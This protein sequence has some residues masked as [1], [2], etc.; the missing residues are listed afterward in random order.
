MELEVDNNVTKNI[1]ENIQI[2]QTRFLETNLGKAINGAIDLGI[3]SIFPDLVENQII[4]IKD[5]ILEQGF[6]EGIKQIINSSIE[7]GKSFAGVFTG[8]FENIS[9]VQNVVKNGGILDSVSELLEFCVNLAKEKEIINSTV[10][11]MM[12]QGKDT[13]I[14]SISNKIE[15]TLTNQLKSVEKLEKYCEKWN[16]Y[17]GN[18][19]FPKMET[20]YNN[21]KKYLEIVMPFENTI[22]N[23]RKI[24]NVH[25]LIKNNNYKFDLSESE[26]I[27]AEK[28]T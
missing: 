14:S 7:M 12:I 13:I 26:I 20:A 6:E 25:N 1:V 15:E 3:K 23:A 22:N 10:S 28:L 21:I 19:D 8:K 18:K 11:N 17:Y 4:E 16:T 27:L 24:E 9:Q 5:A 2:E